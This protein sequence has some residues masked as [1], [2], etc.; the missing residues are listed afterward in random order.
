[1]VQI[2]EADI[3]SGSG[4]GIEPQEKALPFGPTEECSASE[5]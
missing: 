5:M 4:S 1:V 2:H 3:F